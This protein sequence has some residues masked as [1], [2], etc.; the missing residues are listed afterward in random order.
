MNAL[1]KR[2]DIR[3]M[4]TVWRQVFGEGADSIG[5]KSSKEFLWHEGL[6]NSTLTY[7]ARGH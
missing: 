5:S 3:A 7:C 6:G 1:K 2:S 4:T